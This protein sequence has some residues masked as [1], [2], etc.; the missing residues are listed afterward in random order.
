MNY[1]KAALELDRQETAVDAEL[2]T[3]M[4]N[5]FAVGLT[6]KLNAMQAVADLAAQRFAEPFSAVA[7]LAAQRFAE[8]LSA[9]ADLDK[10]NAIAKR[11]GLER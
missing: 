3:N 4:E 9:V 6:D 11:N 2:A 7:D 8:P 10:L 5:L 1:T